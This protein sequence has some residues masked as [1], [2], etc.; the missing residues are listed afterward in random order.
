MTNRKHLMASVAFL[1]GGLVLAGCSSWSADPSMHGN[2]LLDSS[3]IA[4]AQ[5]AAPQN[6]STFDRGLAAEY[7]AFATTL[8]QTASTGQTGDWVDADFFARKS[9]KAGSGVR[10]P[11]EQNANWMV[12]L[13]VP[14]EFRTQLTDGRARLMTALDKGGHERA[15][16]LAA[17]AQERY[18]CWVERMQADWKSA[19]ASSCQQDFTAALAEMEHA[20]APVA[21]AQ[22][23]T[24]ADRHYQAYFDFGK[25]TMTQE[26]RRVVEAVAATARGDGAIRVL[27]LGKTDLAGTDAYNMSLSERRANTVR[28]VLLAR[29]ITSDRVDERWV[30]ERESPVPTAQGVHEVRNRVVEVTL[31]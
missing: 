6:A 1:G 20:P 27:L 16:L 25:S 24:A 29:G 31:R 5:T 23:A 9:L 2:A 4:A 21:A 13:E 12:P 19:M 28:A 7:A 10:V 30:G 15:L 8:S 26:G 17:R 14:Q 3:T 18:D 22:P 11:P